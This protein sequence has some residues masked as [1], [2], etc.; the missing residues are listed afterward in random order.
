MYCA[1]CIARSQICYWLSSD[2]SATRVF[3]Y[4]INAPGTNTPVMCM[5]QCAAFGFSAAGVEVRLHFFSAR[6]W[7]WRS[8]LYNPIISWYQLVGTTMLWV[9]IFVHLST[10]TQCRFSLWWH[11]RCHR[12]KWY[13]CRRFTM[14]HGLRWR[15]LPLMRG[16]WVHERLLLARDEYMAYSGK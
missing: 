12:T 5:N 10:Q 2:N 1:Q 4:Q 13:L 16:L 9:V 7:R 3:P 6:H 11:Y 15:F 8:L 14:Q